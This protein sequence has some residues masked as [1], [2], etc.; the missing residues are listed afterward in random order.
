[1]A[2]TTNPPKSPPKP[3]SKRTA[4][5]GS[6]SLR[7]VLARYSGL[8]LQ[9]GVFLALCAGAGYALDRATGTAIPWFTLACVLAGVTAAMVY[10]VVKMGGPGGKG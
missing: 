7:A 10:M 6:E 9:A 2:D 4:A 5:E 1:M 3:A 8:G